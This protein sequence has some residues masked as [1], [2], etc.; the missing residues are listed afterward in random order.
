MTVLKYFQKEGIDP[1]RLSAQG[2]GEFQ[3]YTE[4]NTLQGRKLNRR[5]EIS[6]DFSK[7]FQ[8]DKK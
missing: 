7:T 2:F 3:P 5:L 6:L 8:K 1:K 4:N